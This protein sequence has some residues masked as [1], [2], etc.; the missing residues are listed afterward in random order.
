[1]N[2][3][4]GHEYHSATNKTGASGDG[5]EVV[6]SLPAERKFRVFV[7]AFALSMISIRKYG[8]ESFTRMHRQYCTRIRPK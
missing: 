3:Q 6:V 8:G 1:M 7:S 2:E 4:W 5:E